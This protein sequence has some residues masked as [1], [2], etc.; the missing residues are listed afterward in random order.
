MDTRWITTSLLLT[1]ALGC[2]ESEQ[3]SADGDAGA[4]RGAAGAAGKGGGAGSGAGAGA[5]AAGGAAG[6]AGTPGI[7]NPGT[8][9]PGSEPVVVPDTELGDVVKAAPSG[10]WT[11]L[12]A[13]NLISDVFPKPSN[14]SCP[15]KSPGAVVG[16]WSGGTASDDSLYV[17]GGGHADY[18]GNELYRFR[19]ADLTWERITEPSAYESCPSGICKTVDGAP[20]S[21]HTYDAVQWVPPLNALW[22]GPGSG[23]KS[24]QLSSQSYLFDI[25]AKAWKPFDNVPLSQAVLSDYDPVT[26]LVII[27]GRTGVV[28]ALNPNTGQYFGSQGNQVASFGYAAASFDFHE[29]QFVSMN[30]TYLARSDLSQV[31]WEDPTSKLP[32][33]AKQVTYTTQGSAQIEFFPPGDT[34]WRWGIVYDPRRKLFLTWMGF[35]ELWMLDPKTWIWSLVEDKTTGATPAASELHKGVFGRWQYLVEYDVYLGYPRSSANPWIFKP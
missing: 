29:R 6:Q 27:G 33:P 20:T 14:P 32:A 9:L 21:V 35:A 30:K 28:T 13:K 12:P 7:P 16:A 22:A 34:G 24:G 8:P 2:S 31:N 17:F 10:A 26:S 15:S 23:W 1:L 3:S 18:C 4:E 19:F 5:G 11:E 25:Q